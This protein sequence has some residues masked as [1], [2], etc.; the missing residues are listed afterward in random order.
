MRKSVRSLQICR[1]KGIQAFFHHFWNIISPILILVFSLGGAGYIGKDNY[2][3]EKHFKFRCL[4]NKISHNPTQS[5]A[6]KC[7]EE[8]LEK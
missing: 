4:L 5:I 2:K 1:T 8:F 6:V 7:F 3:V